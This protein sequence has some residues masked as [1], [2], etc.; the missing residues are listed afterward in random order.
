MWLILIILALV[1]AWMFLG[2]K[3][4]QVRGYSDETIDGVLIQ[5]ILMATKKQLPPG[6]EP[7]DTV[8]VNRKSDGTVES[9]FMFLD[10]GKYSGIQYDVKANMNADGTVSVSS[11]ET[12]L[13]SE[14]EAAYK[15]FLPDQQYSENIKFT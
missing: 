14:L 2:K 12:S 3:S 7:I 1:L 4:P 15:P 13:P 11:V 8:Y 9:R 5:K 10:L 6:Y